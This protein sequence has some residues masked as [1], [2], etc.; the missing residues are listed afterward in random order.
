MRK[1]YAIRNTILALVSQVLITLILFVNRKAFAVIL[2][3]AYLGVNGLFSDILGMLA[4]AEL[5]IGTAIV[6]ALYEP[7]AKNDTKRV[8]ALINFYKK[9]YWTIG[10]VM[11]VVGI[12]II[13]F[14]P[15][16]VSD[17][18]TIENYRIIYLIVLANSIVTYYF[19]YKITII[20]VVQ[21]SY[22][23]NICTTVANFVQTV[24][25][26]FVLIITKSYI[27]YL[28]IQFVC[29]LTMNIVLSNI[30]NRMYP[31][32]FKKENMIKLGKE[33]QNS[34]VK[35]IKALF[36][37]RIGTFLVKGT[38]NIIITMFLGLVSGGVYSNYNMIFSNISRYF[39]LCY[40]AITATVGNYNVTEEKSKTEQM[41]YNIN[42][43][44]F[45]G[46][47]LV[48][49]VLL[50]ATEPFIALWLGADYLDSFGVTVMLALTFYLSQVRSA[51]YVVKNVQ[52]IFYEDR[53]K[54]I[55]ESIVNLV[56]SVIFVKSF[57]VV[58]VL[59]GTF[60][61]GFF[62]GLIVEIYVVYKY[63]FKSSP[64][65]YLTKNLLY[66]LCGFLSSG[67]SCFICGYININNIFT[68]VLRCIIASLVTLAIIFIMFNKSAEF[69][70][71]RGIIIGLINKFWGRK[72]CE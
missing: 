27:F 13:P 50:C 6:F 36:L 17:V 38:D 11:A 40:N 20:T 63:G 69:K 29:T 37:H 68:L 41:F 5:G 28:I 53:F 15:Y 71:F 9:A 42:F 23:Q 12:A 33:E 57:G 72:T 30:S 18:V 21:K 45:S 10:T 3:K 4:V 70:F 62:V 44:S 7:I 66:L 1:V 64:K 51:I 2:G 26:L 39:G 56:V 43:L 31:E 55:V 16:I 34:L 54:P 32:Y 35:N 14:L 65:P 47:V 24:G 67:I 8:G 48:T 49:V 59:I 61:S 52:G 58:G 60:V 19:S 22:I 25:Q 46:S